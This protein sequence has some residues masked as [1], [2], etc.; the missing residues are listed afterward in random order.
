M[1]SD[2]RSPLRAWLCAALYLIAGLTGGHGAV[3]C[4]G[5]SGHVAIEAARAGDCSGC[6]GEA[7]AG[8][9]SSPSEVGDAEPCP[10]DDI[11]LPGSGIAGPKKHES[12]RIADGASRPLPSALFAV[13]GAGGSQVAAER[14]GRAAA[15]SRIRAALARSVVLRV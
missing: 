5:P 1:R 7:G 12:G 9:R 15:A 13:E 8:E 10:C 4:V 11:A 3:L 6:E 14:F 2:R